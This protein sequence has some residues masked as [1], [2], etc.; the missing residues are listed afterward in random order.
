LN[1]LQRNIDQ[2]L[3]PGAIFKYIKIDKCFYDSLLNAQLWFA[4]PT[5]FNDPFDCQ[6]DDQTNWNEDSIKQYFN[7]WNLQKKENID[8]G[9]LIIQNHKQPGSFSNYFN[10]EFK[11]IFKTI[12]VSCF[13]KTPDNPLMWAHYADSH[14]SVCLKFDITLDPDFFQLTCK[15]NYSTE[16]PY[17]DYQKDKNLVFIKAIQTKSCIWSYENEIRVIKLSKPG[18]YNFERSSLK[19]IIFGYNTTDDDILK[20]RTLA[21][22]SKY[23]GL[24]YQKVRLM[25][26]SYEIEIVD[27]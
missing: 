14:R 7:D 15:M 9:D 19:A 23:I 17:I 4:D 22:D 10:R 20:I 21:K 11:N 13:A 24:T 3:I 25:P 1:S 5:T 27:I 12:G 18:L 6:I 16:Y 2:G 26:N 8:P